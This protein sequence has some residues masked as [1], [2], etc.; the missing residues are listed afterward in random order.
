MG[1]LGVMSFGSPAHL[2]AVLTCGKN[3]APYQH[4]LAEKKPKMINS[5]DD[6]TISPSVLP[7]A[8]SY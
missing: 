2:E 4:R 8:S 7:P 6:D 1:F 3:R 5:E